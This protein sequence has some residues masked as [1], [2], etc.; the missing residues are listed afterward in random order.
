MIRT[1]VAVD[2]PV[3]FH[4]TI[5]MLQSKLIGS[6][7]R[8]VD[9]SIVH[10]TMKF[11]GDVDEAK[12]PEIISAIDRLDCPSF[13]SRI[14]GM[15]AF[16]G[17]KNPRIVWLGASG[18]YSCLH[19]QL[20]DILSRIGFKK[21][22]RKFIPHVTLARTTYLSHVRKKELVSAIDS[23]RDFDVGLMNV[24]TVKLKKSTLTPKGPIYETLHEVDLP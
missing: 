23:F 14:S 24:H 10:I 4:A 7:L 15:G 19:E 6:G 3:E 2:I 13:D 1:F 20:E 21:E 18:D 12:L 16:P 5:S 11:L 17:M 9:P 8:P 22:L